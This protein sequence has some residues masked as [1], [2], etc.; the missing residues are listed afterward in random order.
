MTTAIFFDTETSGLPL[1]SEPSEH[2]AQ[3]HI[4]QLAACL[5]DLDTRKTLA[6]MD[7]IIKPD[8]WTIPDEVAKIHGIT[9]EKA[10]DLGV[11]EDLALEMFLGMWAGRP[12]IAHNESFDA[13]IIRIA[14]HRFTTVCDD[15]QRDNWKAGKTECTQIL[16]TPILKLPPTA[17][18]IAARRNHHK[19]ANLGE[20]YKF[21]TGKDLV[22][23]HSAMADVQACMAVYFAI[24]D[25]AAVGKAF[26]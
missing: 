25:Q 24:K 15:Q 2:P 20:A 19:S 11:H 8:G 5:V 4:V 13:R 6:S 7:V 10:V 3:P 12:R 1:F 26:A 21:F 22:D 17:K 9:T 16:S 18:M 14:Q 23:A